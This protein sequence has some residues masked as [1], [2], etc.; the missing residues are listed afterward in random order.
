M[1]NKEN[2][3]VYVVLVTGIYNYDLSTY[4]SLITADKE[5][6]MKEYEDLKQQE[7]KNYADDYGDEVES[8]ELT[9]KTRFEIWKAE[10]S[11]DSS[12]RIEIIE[13]EV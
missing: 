12:T 11:M 9:D 1:E 4:I 5:Q 2:K 6:A 7:I 3:K 8:F 10:Y 13:K